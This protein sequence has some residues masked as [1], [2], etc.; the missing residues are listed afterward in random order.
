M[1]LVPLLELSGLSVRFPAEPRPVRALDGVE[2][3]LLPSERLVLVGESGSGKST[4][5][6][7]I[8]GLLPEEAEVTGSCRFPALGRAP[9][10]GR[11]V[12]LV[13]QDPFTSLN[14]VLSV[15]EQIGE[16]LVTHRSASWSAARQAAVVLLRRVGIPEPERRVDDPP[17]RFSGGQRQRIAIAIAI[18]AGPRLLL[19]DEPTSGLDTVVQAQILDLLDGLVREQGAALLLVTH[20]LA[21]ASRIADRIAVLYAGTLVE[22][23]PAVRILSDPRHP[24][25]SALVAIARALEAGRIDALATVRASPGEPE[26]AARGCP[27]AP[28]CAFAFARCRVER[29]AWSGD[30]RAGVACHLAVP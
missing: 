14:P 27:F 8:A 11:D 1:S 22:C 12:G 5:L 24:Y 4:L 13:L 2:L 28:R 9:V 16:V 29:P 26:A 25:S 20:D 15:G 19:A 18:A 3:E 17:H 10:P 30:R 23:G 21:V 6:W 7:K